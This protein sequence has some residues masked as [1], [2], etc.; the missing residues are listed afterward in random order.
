MIPFYCIDGPLKG[1]RITS[2]FR[3]TEISTGEIYYKHTFVIHEPKL[4]FTDIASVQKELKELEV[5]SNL[6]FYFRESFTCK[7]KA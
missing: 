7:E 2:D 3:P 4:M 6:P 5:N 1:E